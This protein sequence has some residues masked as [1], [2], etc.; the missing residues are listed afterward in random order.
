[1]N[2]NKIRF[3]LLLISILLLTGCTE[4]PFL[5]FDNPIDPEAE[6]FDDQIVVS[7]PGFIE[8]VFPQNEEAVIY[9]R[10]VLSECFEASAYRFQIASSEND[11]AG[12]IIWETAAASA[13]SVFPD[14]D[15]E[16]GTTYYWRG[17]AADS[18]GEWGI[19][20][21]IGSFT[22]GDGV[23]GVSPADAG[24]TL[25]TTPLLD[26]GDVTGAA[27]YKIRFALSDAGLDAAPEKST[28]ESGYQVESGDLFAYGDEV[29][30]QVLAV[31]EAGAEGAWSEVNNFT[32]SWDISWSS[33]TPANNGTTMDTTPLLGWGYVTGA[34]GYKVRF[35]LSEAGL[36][37]APEKSTTESGYQVESGD[38]FAYGDEVF[39]QI[40]AVNEDGAE[41]AW[42]TVNSFSVSWDITW[43]GLSPVDNGSTMDTT[44]LLDW[45][46]VTGAAGY[47]VRFALSEAGLVDELYSSVTDSEYLMETPLNN[48]DKVY[49]QLQPVNPDGVNGAESPVFSF[50]VKIQS[51]ISITPDF[52]DDIEITFSG[53]QS[54]L[55]IGSN[56]TI[57]AGVNGTVDSYIWYLDENIQEGESSNTII[58]GND[59]PQGS[60]TLALVIQVDGELYTD[61]VF[62]VVVPPPEIGDSYA[63]GI[64]FY[65][66]DTGGGLVCAATDQGTSIEWGGNGWSVGGTSTA[67]GTGAANTAA[68]VTAYGDTEPYS[69]LTNYAAK[70][71]S[72]L[73][74]NGYDDWF[75]PSKDELDLMYDNL[76]TQGLGGFASDSYWSSSESSSYYAWYQYFYNG[77]QFSYA[78][79]LNYRVRAV[80]AF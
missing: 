70:L 34:A 67:V 44:P 77:S 29:F 49:W 61:S 38:V 33:F 55:V 24:T 39:W 30:W 31:N 58:I 2:I 51:G 73:E 9:P 14:Y 10:L 57:T 19:F 62:F 64:V 28:T 63:G 18:G 4:N 6:S 22:V 15:W 17:A 45:D 5:S 53:A 23:S 8:M 80:R 60:Y 75:L 12:S 71:C 16:K 69:G 35:A 11:F 1:M 46:D 32:V 52:G 76:K 25:D 26:W 7:D 68:I 13:S 56:M 79:H 37:A 74:L 27:G 59:L 54:E 50:T 48:G 40:L 20:S 65:L 78:K 36:D 47:K 43:S 3:L 72:D 21:G 41:G 42:S 66:D